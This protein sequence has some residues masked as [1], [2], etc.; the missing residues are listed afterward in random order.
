M[1]SI[2]KSQEIKSEDS[3]GVQKTQ[4]IKYRPLKNPTSISDDI[5]SLLAKGEG[6][7]MENLSDDD[8]EENSIENPALNEQ[9]VSKFFFSRKFSFFREIILV[10]RCFKCYSWLSLSATLIL[11]Y[12]GHL[13]QLVEFCKNIRDGL[14]FFAKIKA[15]V[16]IC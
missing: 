13:R 3:G 2:A 15:Q 9:T 12:K 14:V 7:A 6:V 16:T 10:F 11:F 5:K 4:K 1:E 8:S